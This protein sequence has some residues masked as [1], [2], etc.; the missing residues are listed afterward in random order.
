V[1]DASSAIQPSIPILAAGLALAVPC[2]VAAS[3]H[4]ISKIAL[5]GDVAPGTGGALHGD[6]FFSVALNDAGEAAFLNDLTGGPP[7]WGAFLY[8]PGGNSALS[9]EGDVAPDTGGRTYFL[10]GGFTS[11]NDDGEVS[12]AAVALNGS[13]TTGIFLDSSGVEIAV[14]VAGQPAPDAGLGTF[15]AALNAIN[16]HSLNAGGD[17]AFTDTVTGGTIGS[18]VFRYSG[19]THTSVSLEGEPAPGTGGGAYDGFQSPVMNDAGD[20]VFP[21]FVSGG[22]GASGGL[23]RDSGGVDSMLALEGHSAPDT[24]GGTFVDFLFPDQNSGGDVAFLANVTGGT[25]AGGVFRIVDGVAS[26]VAVD[27]G[28]APGT[29][30]GTYATITSL[31]PINDSG[32]VAFSATF[33][34]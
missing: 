24:G 15:D 21:A 9:L 20:V 12:F 26:A 8:G 1:K 14:V 34:G 29:G 11:L 32:D 31:A 13:T 33:S 18:G 5:G 2:S 7:G 28:V 19:G 6:S 3:G 4:T 16:S 25:A 30:G 17:V 23:F 22:S 27:G 10:A